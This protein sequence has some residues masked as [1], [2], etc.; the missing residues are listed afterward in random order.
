M[1]AI[2]SLVSLLV[3]L[4]IVAVLAKKQLTTVTQPPA[5]LV[6]GAGTGAGAVNIPA[7]TP[8]QAIP[9]QFKSAVETTLQQPRP[10]D[11]SK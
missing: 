7:G 5:I 8:P 3:V 10:V 11:D 9:Q 2:F 4:G 6:P 1:K